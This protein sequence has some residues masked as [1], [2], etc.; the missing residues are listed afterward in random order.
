MGIL[1]KVKEKRIPPAGE[2]NPMC[3]S[4]YHSVKKKVKDSRNGCPHSKDM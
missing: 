4:V 2:R 3:T 1:G